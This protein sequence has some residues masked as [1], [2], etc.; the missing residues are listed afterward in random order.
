M[1]KDSRAFKSGIDALDTARKK[2]GKAKQPDDA[3]R[4]LD[5]AM[6]AIMQARRAVWDQNKAKAGD[7]APLKPKAAPG[8]R[9]EAKR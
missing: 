1:L 3:L 7:T 5:D 6:K 9:A 4:A 2:I 8:E